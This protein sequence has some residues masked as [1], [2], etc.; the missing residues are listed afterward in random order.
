VSTYLVLV[1]CSILG[2]LVSLRRV[3]R[4]DPAQA[5]GSAQ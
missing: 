3:V 4:I 1:V 2:S 5:I